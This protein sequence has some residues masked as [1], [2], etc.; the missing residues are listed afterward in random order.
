MTLLTEMAGWAPVSIHPGMISNRV[1]RASTIGAHSPASSNSGCPECI[2]KGLV[3]ST[4]AT[5]GIPFINGE[6]EAFTATETMRVRVEEVTETVPVPPTLSSWT[7]EASTH[8]HHPGM[9]SLLFHLPGFTPGPPFSCLCQ[10]V[11]KGTLGSI[12]LGA[13]CAVMQRRMQE[14]CRVCNGQDN[15]ATSNP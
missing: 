3:K 7:L 15:W 1:P 8:C 2:R 6:L 11:R 12:V 14:R 4:R 9:G 13:S 10:T 5:Q